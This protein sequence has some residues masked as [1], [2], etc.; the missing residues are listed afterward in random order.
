MDGKIRMKVMKFGGSS[1]AAPRHVRDVVRII[2]NEGKRDQIV[3]VVSAFQGITNQLLAGAR[4]AEKGDA[5]Y[6]TLFKQIAERHLDALDALHGKGKSSTVCSLIEQHLTE[7]HDAL[8]GISLLRHSPPRAMDLVAS[9]GERLSALTL[10]SFIKKSKASVYADAR[11]FIVTDDQ[12]MNASVNFE[13]TNPQTKKYFEKLYKTNG[14]NCIAVVTGFTGVTED[15]RTTTIGRNGSDYSAAI[16]GAA[17]D[18]DVVEI[19]TDVDGVLSADPRAVSSAFVLPSLSYEEAMEM[20]YFLERQHRDLTIIVATSGDTGSAVAHGFFNVPHIN[21]FILY[22]SGKISRLQEQQ[23]TTLGGNITAVEVEGTFDDCQRLVKQ[24]LN[25]KDVQKERALT[26]AN[27]INLG[28][29]LPQV[30]YYDWGLIQLREKFKQEE[31]PLVVVPSG[32]FGNLTAA[33][34]AKWMGCPIRSFVAATNAN[35]GVLHYLHSGEFIPRASIQTYSNAM[36]VGNPSN[37]ARLQFLYNNDVQHLRQDIDAVSISDEET[38]QEICA[39]Y[40]T[41]SYI[42][43]PHTAVGV[44]AARRAM[45]WMSDAPPI[46]VAATAHPAKFPDVVEKA[47]GVEVPL[48]ATLQEA[49]NRPKHSIKIR[50]RYSEWKELLNQSNT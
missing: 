5:S 28:R 25:D 48:P 4:L 6:L 50:G 45:E 38:L 11:E 46:I 44:A 23:M 21:V 1:V 32:N 9:F 24:A 49:V 30:T 8:H 31:Q 27:S 12:F 18:V 15:G 19:W 29:L 20:S 2:L 35:D 13:L 22:P 14:K 42:L 26:T 16:V 34:Y 43:D 3:V 10:A 40:E 39:T 41:T 17:L 33:V 47:I 37:L 36:D 7:L